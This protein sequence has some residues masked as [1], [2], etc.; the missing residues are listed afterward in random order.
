MNSPETSV[1]WLQLLLLVT[2]WT[3]F[4]VLFS[5]NTALYRLVASDEADQH[6]VFL[7]LAQYRV[8]IWCWLF[9]AGSGLGLAVLTQYPAMAA[10]WPQSAAAQMLTF[11]AALAVIAFLFSL[12]PWRFMRDHAVVRSYGWVNVPQYV[13]WCLRIELCLILLVM[14]V[15]AVIRVGKG[16]PL[17]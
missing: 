6:R 10:A 5:A 11:K 7:G 12:P 9:V 1:I 8:G 4:L 13:R 16:L 17:S 15:A 2:H 3:A 14:A